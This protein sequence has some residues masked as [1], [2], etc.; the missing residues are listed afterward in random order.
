MFALA[1]QHDE[2]AQQDDTRATVLR[3]AHSGV[4][5]SHGSQVPIFTNTSDRRHATSGETVYARGP[6]DLYFVLGWSVSLCALRYAVQAGVLKP[7]AH[8]AGQKNAMQV[9]KFAENG[10]QVR[11]S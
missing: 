3:I 10:W 7:L 5:L 8:L 4:F 9:H 6:L 2:T 11:L 1:S